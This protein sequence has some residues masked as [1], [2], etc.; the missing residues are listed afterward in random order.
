[1]S[2]FIAKYIARMYTIIVCPTSYI[3]F[4]GPVHGRKSVNL[5][6]KHL[7]SVA[8]ILVVMGVVEDGEVEVAAEVVVEEEVVTVAIT[9]MVV[10][11]KIEQ[12]IVEDVVVTVV[13][14]ETVEHGKIIRIDHL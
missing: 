1:M 3:C 9:L 5:M 12:T 10:T 4:S 6:S 13:I 7:V 11:N 14:V 8:H 2:L